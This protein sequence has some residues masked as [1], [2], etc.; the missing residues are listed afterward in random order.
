[1]KFMLNGAITIG[2]MDGAN[3]EMY[4]EV[5][6]DNIFI[7][8]MS[9]EEVIAHENNR[10]YNPVDIYNNDPEIRQ[11]LNQLVDGTYS[12]NDRELFRELY[13]SLLNPQQGQVADR[14]F[15]LAD[16]RA[17]ANA[18]KK[19]SAYYQNKSA[20][21]KS[22]ILNVAH[23]GKFSSDRTIQEFKMENNVMNNQSVAGEHGISGY[24]LKMIAVITMLIDHSAATIL[25]RILVQMPSW[26]PVTVDNCEQWYRLDLL[27]R[28]IGRMAFPIY[29]F[30]L[31]EG[32]HYTHSRRKYAARMFVFALISEV[33]FDMAL[34]QSVLELSYNNVFFTLFLGL[35]VIM[36]ADRVM[37]RFSSDNLTSEI[38]RIIFLV[39]I[40]MVGCA[41][42]S[43]VISCDYGAS[44][45]IA[46]YIMYLLRSK[47]ELGFALAVVSLGVFSGELELLAL[48]M[49]IPLHFYNG[50]RGKQHKY[51]F[52]AFY[53]LHLLLLA[54]IAWG[55][56]LGI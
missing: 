6:A 3:V 40:G 45:V 8:G 36:A 25:E 23:V 18:Q 11:V 2:T 17:Y 55:L 43:Y 13:N 50:T 44:G 52:Y 15:I 35:L 48:L 14:Y 27:L 29:C 49:L 42:A 39:V 28:G 24:W 33:P 53:P 19:I 16:F 47:R 46:I 12:Q 10:D 38:G 30:L 32:F 34:N 22:A 56:G 20:W 31:V 41:L 21:A 51:F 4:E 5:G 7:F 37:E 26:A 1:M 54:L 9:A